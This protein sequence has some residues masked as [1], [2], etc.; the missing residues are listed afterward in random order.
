[1]GRDSWREDRRAQRS[2]A[3]MMAAFERLAMERPVSKIT[4]SALAGE[5]GVDRKTFYQHF[6]SMEGLLEARA[7][8]MVDEV[9]DAVARVR[10]EGGEAVGEP[11]VA[12]FFSAV[13]EALG[14]KVALNRRLLGDMPTEELLRHLER[15]L[16]RGIVE[17]GLLPDGIDEQVMRYALSFELGGLLALYRSWALAG[18][19]ASLEAATSVARSL[20]ADGLSGVV[21]DA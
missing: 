8:E 12:A 16:S 9:L 3:A 1:M 13:A 4:V 15:P 10:S 7:R 20:A 2:R 11:E 14:E 17:R 21:P 6:G 18:E 5:A 19:G